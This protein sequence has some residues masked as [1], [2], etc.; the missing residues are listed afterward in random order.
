MG[1]WSLSCFTV[2][3]IDI[4][5]PP[6]PSVARP[7]I[8]L[9]VAEAQSAGPGGLGVAGPRFP[10]PVPPFLPPGSPRFLLTQSAPS[11]SRHKPV[12]TADVLM[13]SEPALAATGSAGSLPARVF[14]RE[15]SLPSFFAYLAIGSTFL[16][17]PAECEGGGGGDGAR[18]PPGTAGSLPGG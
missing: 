13:I 15:N 10:S 3:V 12:A 6:G 17:A 9:D 1:F 11:V 2:I 4:R 18:P 14:L 16:S 7:V 5:L 8:L